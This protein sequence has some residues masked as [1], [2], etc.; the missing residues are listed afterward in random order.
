MGLHLYN[1]QDLSCLSNEVAEL[2]KIKKNSKDLLKQEYFIVTTSGIRRFLSLDVTNRNMVFANA[3]FL[4]PN[5]AVKMV[6]SVVC[7]DSDLKSFSDTNNLKWV[8][9]ELILKKGISDPD[10]AFIKNYIGNPINQKKLFHL[11]E[12]IADIFDK[13]T[14]YRHDLIKAWENGKTLYNGFKHEKWQMKL[15]NYYKQS[16]PDDLNKYSIME[17]INKDLSG[18]LP[19]KTKESL[20]ARFFVFGISYLAKYY[21]RFLELLSRHIEIYLFCFNPCIEYWGDIRSDKEIMW[22]RK[23]SRNGDLYMGNG[24]SLLANMGKTGRDF[25]EELYEIENLEEHEPRHGYTND[26]N[27]LLKKIQ[28]DIITLSTRD[29][30][31]IINANDDS[32]V[33]AICHSP[34]REV[35][36]LHDRLLKWFEDDHTLKPKDILVMTPDIN[37]YAPYPYN[38]FYFFECSHIFRSKP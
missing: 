11:S 33:F 24:N 16:C 17:L 26:C 18:S 4:N 20:P 32:L 19:C 27:T 25:F 23:K 22:A 36:A 30:D 38:D 14:I 15:W 34:M 5:E 2:I 10:C 21:I 6:Y 3:K 9:M 12:S 37:L 13:Y 7:P 35:E 28:Y 8:L 31:N 1:S 29:K